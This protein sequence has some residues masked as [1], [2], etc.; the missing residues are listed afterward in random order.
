MTGLEHK[1]FDRIVYVLTALLLPQAALATGGAQTADCPAQTELVSHGFDQAWTMVTGVNAPVMAIADTGFLASHTDL[2]GQIVG[3]WDYGNNDP[4]PEV[5]WWSTVPSH[6][7]F[8]AALMVG[9]DDESGRTGAVPDGQVLLQGV[10]DSYGGLFFSYAS[11]AMDDLVNY[12]EVGVFNYSIASLDPPASFEQAVL[13]LAD[14][15]VLM[16]TSAGNCSQPNCASANNDQNPVYPGSFGF[17]HVLS[18]ASSLSDGSRDPYSHYGPTSV[19]L[20]AQGNSLCSAVA[21]GNNH[22]AI[23][24]GTSYA[25]PLVAGAAALVRERF[26]RLIAE[27]VAS[28]LC[29]SA[30]PHPDVRCG[31]LAVDAALLTTWVDVQQVDLVGDNLEVSIDSLGSQGVVDVVVTLPSGLLLADDPSV[32]Q[33]GASLEVTVQQ[34]VTLD[35]TGLWQIPLIKQSAGQGEVVVRT[36]QG[37]SQSEARKVISWDVTTDEVNQEEPTVQPASGCGCAT[38]QPGAMWLVLLPLFWR[39]RRCSYFSDTNRATQ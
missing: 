13:G 23:E 6:G 14:N 20:I 39:H 30:T 33:G 19:D 1:L 38:S 36:G 26:P 34:T 27:E 17:P 31:T 15:D 24:S 11:D 22:Y 9:I 35:A 10:S 28:V 7:T 8:I 4:V 18:V 5:N 37:L 32:Q 29:T 3:G 21:T 25:G 16:V 12:P 2:E